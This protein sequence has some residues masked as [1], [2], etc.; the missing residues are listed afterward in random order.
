MGVLF[1][2]DLI[3][4]A[5]NAKGVVGITVCGSQSPVGFYNSSDV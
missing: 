4:E 2:E 3:T 5:I 1:V